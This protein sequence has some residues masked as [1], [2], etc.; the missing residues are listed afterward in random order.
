L[1][2]IGIG[3]FKEKSEWIN[4]CGEGGPLAFFYK[5][6]PSF[7]RMRAMPP[8]IKDKCLTIE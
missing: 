8:V 2:K 1:K 7:S 5:A 3:A 4:R 6:A